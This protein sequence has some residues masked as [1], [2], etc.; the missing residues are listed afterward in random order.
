[1]KT[2]HT[3]G[4]WYANTNGRDTYIYLKNDHPQA[5]SSKYVIGKV[6]KAQLAY[7]ANAQLMA[8]AP[9]ILKE[10]KALVHAVKQAERTHTSVSESYIESAEEAIKKATS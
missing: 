9:E 2:K 1:M 10:L 7:K 4:Q 3:P 5:R 8:S 6:S